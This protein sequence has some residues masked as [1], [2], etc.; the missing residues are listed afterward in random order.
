M[1][2]QLRGNSQGV[3][4][5]P[6]GA[7]ALPPGAGPAV[8]VQDSP[9]I[10]S[11][12]GQQCLGMLALHRATR[13][14]VAKAKQ[15]GVGVVGVNNTAS[16]TGA[17]GCAAA[18]F[19]G[20]R[21]EAEAARSMSSCCKHIVICFDAC[22]HWVEQIAEAGL[23]GVIMCQSP[24][25]VAPHGSTEAIFGTNPIAVGCPTDEGPFLIDL[26]TSAQSW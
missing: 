17:L 25:Y 26:A 4:K 13:L 8:V 15:G 16:T 14:A 9:G 20:V 11:I 3:I 18:A 6:S 24:E 1:W 7:F 21:L 22:R 5:I 19:V 10:A 23:V 2:S 12:N